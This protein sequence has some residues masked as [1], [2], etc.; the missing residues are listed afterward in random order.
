MVSN[1]AY[2]ALRQA[3]AGEG[4]LPLQRSR[5]KRSNIV[6]RGH[7]QPHQARP[8]TRVTSTVSKARLEPSTNVRLES[9]WVSI[10]SGSS[11]MGRFTR[12]PRQPPCLDSRNNRIKTA[13]ERY[14][15]S[16][17]AVIQRLDNPFLRV[18]LLFSFVLDS[19]DIR[20]VF[21]C[22]ISSIFMLLRS[23]LP[24]PMLEA[25]RM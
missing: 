6:P 24:R 10:K 20:M 3:S 1:R 4:R 22:V 17:R 15:T 16:L 13:S 9:R 21:H 2:F 23:L 7:T 14:W 11:R 8:K 19:G 18:T 5:G 25:A 12:S